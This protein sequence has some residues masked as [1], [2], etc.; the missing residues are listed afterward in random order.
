MSNVT[1][2]ALTRTA[3]T[4]LYSYAHTALARERLSFRVAIDNATV[5]TDTTINITSTLPSAVHAAGS[6]AAAT[7]VRDGDA[8]RSGLAGPVPLLASLWH[9]LFVPVL[10]AGGGGGFFADPGLTV[11]LLLSAA[12]GPNAT[13]TS[14]TTAVNTTALV[15]S[16]VWSSTNGSYVVP[17]KLPSNGSYSGMLNIWPNASAAAFLVRALHMLRGVLVLPTALLPRVDPAAAPYARARRPTARSPLRRR[18]C[19][20]WRPPPASA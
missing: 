19:V 18:R 12:S 7:L 3:Q 16:G 6:L 2:A 17:F 13:N 11:R 5:S 14:N 10:R 15:F 8:S 1:T 4:G 9:V 20:L